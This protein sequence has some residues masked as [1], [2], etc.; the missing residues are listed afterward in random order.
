MK[1][2]QDTYFRKDCPFGAFS[3]TRIFQYI[4][5]KED[6]GMTIL[7]FLK[8]R[9]FSRHILS[10]MKA[11]KEAIL[12]NGERGFGRTCLQENDT[13][14]VRLLETESSEK[15][16]PIS[17]ELHILFEDED[18]L[19]I[20]KGAN[21]PIH[22]SQGNYENTLA[23]GVA[24]YYQSQG[25]T[26]VYRCINRL[27]RD[28]TG[29]LILAKNALSAALLSQQMLNRQIKRTYLALATGLVPESGTISAPI[30]RVDGS[31]IEREVNFETGEDAVTHF[32][33]LDFKNDFSL[34]ELHLETG[35]THQIRVH[36]KHI[37]HPLPGDF[38]YNP[39]YDKISR[40]ALHS[41]Q[42]EFTHPI[43]G[44]P[45]LF[46]APVPEDFRLAFEK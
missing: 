12:L 45:L 22:P 15:I 46:T 42:I 37:G 24:Y 26:F 23:N 38:L 2:L 40:Q 41:Y 20:N 25:E 16:V 18:L 27:D 34:I 9:G 5:Q 35:R 7:D 31:T 19:V 10:S 43:T 21:T 33:R 6:S 44:Q 28:T 13:L 4:I 29:A 1:Q 32:E 14:R 11:D 8:K 39:V 3:M 36:M 30:A 17:M